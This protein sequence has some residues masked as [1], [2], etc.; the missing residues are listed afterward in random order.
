MCAP[1]CAAR[2]HHS[3]CLLAGVSGCDVWAGEGTLIIKRGDLARGKNISGRRRDSR[4][5]IQSAGMLWWNVVL[6]L[7]NKSSQIV[8]FRVSFQMQEYFKW[9]K[10]FL[11]YYCRYFHVWIWKKITTYR[12]LRNTKQSFIWSLITTNLWRS[13]IFPRPKVSREIPSQRC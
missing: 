8:C 13:A 6:F 2:A 3:R 7:I 12:T 10:T 9:T 4:R 11:F 5:R 1:G